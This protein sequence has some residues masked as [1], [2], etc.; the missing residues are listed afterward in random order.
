M[1]TPNAPVIAPT[2][3]GEEDQE[4]MFQIS[5]RVFIKASGAIVIVAGAAA[6]TAGCGTSGLPP[7]TTPIPT[8]Q[9]FPD[10]A[11]IADLP[12]ATDGLHFFTPDE[13]ETVEAMAAR[14]IPG[15]ASDPGAREAGVVYFI[16]HMMAFH[17][18]DD[19]ATYRSGPFIKEYEV[20]NMPTNVDPTKD[21]LVL[22]DDA[23]RYGYQSSMTPAQEYR[24]GIAAVDKYAN[25]K[26]GKRFVLLSEDQQDTILMDMAQGKAT[27]FDKPSDESFFA[28]LREHTLYGM[29]SD[30]GYGGNRNFAGWN[31]IA[32]PG[33]QRG[34]TPDEMRT[35][36]FRRP[37]QSLAQ[38]MPEAHGQAG[39]GGVLTVPSGTQNYP[40]LP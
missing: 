15:D 20:G 33:S 37:P 10:V 21:V 11:D 18:G 2:E 22:K 23:P 31:L 14:I 34:W 1:D 12:P 35:E 25:S 30:P 3:S 8:Q 40:N 26:F 29:F 13:A 38:L 27:G 6:I 32:Y 7:T 16:D 36:G 24:A 5:R 4:E 28:T 17:D 39:H 9:Q 19:E